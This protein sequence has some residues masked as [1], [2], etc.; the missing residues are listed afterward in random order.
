MKC[1]PAEE[2][3]RRELGELLTHRANEVEQHLLVCASCVQRRRDQLELL[4][5]L[6]SP[7]P[8]QVSDSAF[9]EGV[10][11]HCD[12]PER[13]DAMV[14]RRSVRWVVGL[15]A[16][17]ALAASWLF[18]PRLA[19]QQGSFVAR[20]AKHQAADATF[21]E[22]LRVRANGLEPIRGA[23]LRPG[24]GI[25]V[26]FSNAGLTLRYLMVFALD[27]QREIHWIYPAYL[28]PAS[29]PRAVTLASQRTVQLLDEAVEPEAP[30]PGA[31]R[32][33]T[34]VLSEPMTVKDVENRI[35]GESPDIKR[36]FPAAQVNEWGCT[37]A[38]K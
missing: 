38:A 31:L 7:P 20:G 12:T 4:A 8:L 32:I 24:D 18:V 35:Q 36:L 1:P 13:A 19:Q 5:E 14:P 26:R 6:S 21:V 28:D 25:G 15:A 27:S 37:W 29:N 10:L 16:A 17:A 22:V 30:A 2:L 23:T 33:V 9:I 34:M 11:R 3:L